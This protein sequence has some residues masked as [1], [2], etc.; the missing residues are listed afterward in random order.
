MLPTGTAK[1]NHQILEIALLIVVDSR[2]RQLENTRE[3][4]VYAFLLVQIIDHRRVQS[5]QGLETFLAARIRQATSIEYEAAAVA[6]FVFRQALVKGKTE[7][8]H[9]E[10]LRLRSQAQQFFRSQ[11]AVEAAHQR[12][13]FDRKLH[14]MQ[15][16]ANVFQRVR[17]ALQ[18]VSPALIEPA[19]PVGAQSLQNARVDIRIVIVQKGFAV[20]GEH[21]G[22]LVQIVI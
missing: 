13:K 10:I 16:P 1:G 19:K 6:G 8:A 7:D 22:E 15:Q 18:K 21:F 12:G 3:E 17:H 11:H 14:M 2:V 9:N 4:L 20:Q 5:R